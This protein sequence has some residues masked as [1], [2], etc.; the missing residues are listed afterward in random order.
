MKIAVPTEGHRKLSD[1]VA[2]TFS[3]AATFTIISLKDNKPGEVTVIEN[4]ART[5]KQGAGPLAA[6]TLKGQDVTAILSGE[7]G[8]GATTILGAFDIEVHQTETGKKVKIALAEWL[9]TL[10]P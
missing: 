2:D 10:E 3:R 7:I 9:E 8:P 5:Q 6:K 4:Q 1:K